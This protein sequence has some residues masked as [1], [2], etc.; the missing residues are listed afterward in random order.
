[1]GKGIIKYDA[2]DTNEAL[3][4]VIENK[5]AFPFDTS[6]KELSKKGIT[7]GAV[8]EAVKDIKSKAKGY[9]LTEDKLKKAYPESDE[10]SKAYVGR[11]Y[12]YAIYLY[13]TEQGGWYD[14]KQTGGD[15]QFNAGDFYSKMEIDQK[16][17]ELDERLKV[18]EERDVFLSVDA[19]ESIE[20]EDDKLY[21]IFEEE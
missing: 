4:I 17:A 20:P 6:P 19:F 10:G 15:E 14:T 7:S 11:N 18:L 8:A 2:A 21:F 16:N 13:D 9:F 5:D 1:M 3:G 12:P